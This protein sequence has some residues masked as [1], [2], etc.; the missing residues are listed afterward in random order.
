VFAPCEPVR[1]IG[2]RP[3][4]TYVVRMPMVGPG[5]KPQ[6]AVAE[7]F[8]GAGARGDAAGEQLTQTARRIATLASPNLARVRDVNLHDDDL[9]VI[10][11]FVEGEKLQELWPPQK[12]PLEVALR[13]IV[14]VLTGVG[15]LH[16]LRDSK[17]QPLKLAHGEI[18][19]ATIVLGLDGVTRVLHAV[20]RCA[21]GAQAELRSL[22]YL[23]PEV[24]AGEPYDARADV[25]GAG[26]LLWE[27]LAGKRLF[28]GPE[29]NAA[30][31][32]AR[33]TALPR[34][35]VPDKAPWAK[36]LVDVAA[37]ALALAPGDRW[38]T[39]AAMAA[40]VRKAAGL[41]LAPASTSA[42]FAKS[43]LSERV[44]ARRESLQGGETVAP[45]PP[46]AVATPQ[47]AP[48]ALPRAADAEPP[49]AAPPPPVEP[50]EGPESDSVLVAPGI[51][52]PV[53]EV[54]ELESESLVDAA[55]SV[56]PPAAPSGGSGFVVDPFAASAAGTRDA[57]PAPF[58]APVPLPVVPASP[59]VPVIPSV[60]VPVDVAL[61][62]PAEES[63]PSSIGG[64]QH[65]A[66]AI[67]LLP[68]APTYQA[69]PAA[70]ESYRDAFASSSLEDAQLT[71][72]ASADL[73]RRKALVLG[74]VGLLGLVV[75]VLAAVRVAQRG[76]D[77][78]GTAAAAPTTTVAAAAAPTAPAPT[79][80]A[81]VAQPPSSPVRS[82]PSPATAAPRP[83][84]QPPATNP[85][86]H[87]AAP[88]RAAA[89]ATHST[90]APRPRSKQT[91]D[92]NSP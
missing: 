86:P 74:G 9:V 68:P 61:V 67:D 24:G 57:P 77:G 45:P 36:G 46:A 32:R 62:P 73:R 3:N 71:A 78:P 14:D 50:L 34:A 87:K 19:P 37:K 70:Q 52:A 11:E 7:R 29:E 35:P 33:G 22:G 20:S 15:M 51:Q 27:A 55:P 28:A 17:Q 5:A 72:R 66:A 59:P 31:C 60:P 42:A 23:A 44:R 56:Q 48:V 8:A 81:S 26:V 2:A 76:N 79:A 64:P 63:S 10:G 85:R 43:A 92:P 16:N 30:V 25:F 89:P 49:P 80:P 65:F 4:P 82:T 18:S 39:A 84:A 47:P 13:A 91:F 90:A 53:A 1:E 40:E 69:P 38:P 75:F 54:V 6:L 88:P 12:L 21:G 83:A 41:K 58:A